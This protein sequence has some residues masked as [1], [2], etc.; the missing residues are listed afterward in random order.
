MRT[1]EWKTLLDWVSNGGFLVLPWDS[2]QSENPAL[3]EVASLLD[4][5]FE[6][7][8]S[9]A[10]A[11]R[12]R[13]LTFETEHIGG[14]CYDLYTR[15]QETLPKGFPV[16]PEVHPERLGILKP[17][18][19]WQ[20]LA[21]VLA[22]DSPEPYWPL[23]AEKRLGKG[24]LFI[25]STDWGSQYLQRRNPELRTWLQDLIHW[26]S[27]SEPAVRVDGPRNLNSY[28][29]KTHDA[30]ILYLVN[31]SCDYQPRRGDWHECMQVADKPFQIGKV[32]IQVSGMRTLQ[33]LHGPSPDRSSNTEQG[34]ELAYD[35]FESHAVITFKPRESPQKQP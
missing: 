25:S 29:T 31:I 24:R 33:V 21:D 2:C 17:G 18:P 30:L 27:R 34:I 3:E 4:L 15:W 9:M 35:T 26:G 14:Q 22:S 1:D 13:R 8:S 28:V 16:S 11:T 5:A 6:P 7:S 19:S 20:L 23:M 32:T 10:K 12:L